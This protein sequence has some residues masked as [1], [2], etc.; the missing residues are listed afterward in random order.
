MANR[1]IDFE[2]TPLAIESKYQTQFTFLANAPLSFKSTELELSV[3]LMATHTAI[4]NFDRETKKLAISFTF[5][6][7]ATIP[8]EAGITL[9]GWEEVTG[10]LT[11]HGGDL[12]GVFIKATL[13][14]I[15]RKGVSN[16][17]ELGSDWVSKAV[18]SANEELALV[19]RPKL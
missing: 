1:T 14:V 2:I 17:C 15:R 6:A 12:D 9:A 11:S 4:A 13:K 19:R 16:K 5:H 18:E 10:R 3:Q 7:R 8:S